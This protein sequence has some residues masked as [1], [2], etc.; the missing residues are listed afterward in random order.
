MT[1]IGYRKPWNAE[2]DG[3]TTQEK[4]DRVRHRQGWI[5]SCVAKPAFCSESW[6]RWRSVSGMQKI[7]RI[8]EERKMVKKVLSEAEASLIREEPRF[9]GIEPIKDREISLSFQTACSKEKTCVKTALQFGTDCGNVDALEEEMAGFIGV[10][11]AVALSSGTEAVHA[12]PRLAAEKVYG[13]LLSGR[14]VFCSDLAASALVNSVVY[15]GGEPVFIDASPEDWGMDPDALEIA[16][17]RYPDVKIVMMAHLYGFPG[18]VEK[19]KRICRK[20]GAVLIEDACE[21]LGA[22]IKGKQV[23]SFGDYGV[24]SFHNSDIMADLEGGML[25]V[26]DASEA[27]KVR[28]WLSQPPMGRPQAQRGRW[29]CR[30]QTGNVQA[31]V[32]HCRMRSLHE[33]IAKKKRIYERYQRRF[34]EDLMLLNP[35]GEGTEPSYWHSC[36]T[37]ESSIGFI[38]RRSERE[39]EYVSQHG[40]AAPM[41][42]LDALA[43]F[44]AEGKPVW[45]PMHMQ[46]FF[47]DCDQV[48]LDG[49]KKDYES[50][51][52][53]GPLVRCNESA[54]IFRKGICLPADV[55]MTEAEQN[56]VIDIIFSCYCRRDMNREIW[57]AMQD[58]DGYK[59]ERSAER[60][61]F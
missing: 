28:G 21:S 37:V 54:E 13:G 26:N 56:R 58:T 33:Y 35:V 3:F 1:G 47:K 15:E 11:H 43:A 30:D 59:I 5:F 52:H 14:R 41:E 40:T 17:H 31:G 53:K 19:V 39:Y 48:S 6:K 22:L 7:N 29:V 27:E 24:L 16:F 46:P 4:A 25:L 57:C 34:A 20:H 45:K 23:G 50:S 36:M 9:Y 12:A 18:Q 38:E 49:S 55:R 51:G 8:V 10:K 42:I 2:D 44:G 32:I 60:R 61:L